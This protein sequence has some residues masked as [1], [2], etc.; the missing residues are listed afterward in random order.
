[1]ANHIAFRT[2]N[3]DAAGAW[4][5]WF[6][7]FHTGNPPTASQSGAMPYFGTALSVDLNTLGAYSA[8]GIHYQPAN[9]GASAAFHYTVSEAG[10]LE[11][12]PSAYGCQQEYTT[13]GT[14]RKFVRG[15]S[16][17]W[18]GKDGPWGPR[19]D[20]LLTSGGEVTGTLDQN[21][22]SQ[23]AYNQ[24]ALSGGSR[25]GKI[26]LRKVRGGSGDTIWHE[27]VQENVL[28]I[29]T[30]NTDA[31]EEMVLTGGV[32]AT[33][34]GE[35]S[36]SAN[37]FRI[38]YG[39]YGAF[40]RNDGV[41]LYLMLTKKNDPHGSYNALRPFYV[42]LA[43]GYPIM[44]HLSLTDYTN[45]DAR[46]LGHA[47]LTTFGAVGSLAFLSNNTATTIA[48]GATVAGSSMSFAGVGADWART[49]ATLRRSHAAG[50]LQVHGAAWATGE[51]A[52]TP[53][54]LSGSREEKGMLKTPAAPKNARYS[55][56]DNSMIDCII[57]LSMAEDSQDI[58]DV[59]FT[60][61]PDDP[62]EY[63]RQR[64]ADLVAGKHGEVEPYVPPVTE[65]PEADP[66]REKNNAAGRS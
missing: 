30:G 54:R 4:N 62:E 59:P 29:A 27:T 2:R 45:F 28:R 50:R 15:L 13:F 33:F 24:T 6:E 55:A 14:G 5:L 20:Y 12:T 49:A 40:L 58:L 46:Y 25:G 47:V 42:V 38:A 44:S 22:V 66:E 10:T 53:P 37:G 17:P 1:V 31:E 65:P 32:S 35:I 8:A 26:Y 43:T 11:V 63:S 19:K 36:G 61:S 3:G 57:G 18:N 48:P 16:G 60:A 23:A 51:M 64:F 7:L 56:P 21:S 41:H 52:A 9:A 39:G 34:R